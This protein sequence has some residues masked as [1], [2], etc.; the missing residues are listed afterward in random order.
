MAKRERSL[1]DGH[2]DPLR[3]PKRGGYNQGAVD[4]GQVERRW[5]ELPVDDAL[6]P[7]SNLEADHYGPGQQVSI[8]DAADTELNVKRWLDNQVEAGNIYDDPD[9]VSSNG[10]PPCKRVNRDNRH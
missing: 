8:E 7:G 4:G 6:S 3:L 2:A 1:G 10:L 5:G 9:Q